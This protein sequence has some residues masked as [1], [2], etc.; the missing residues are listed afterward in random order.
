MNAQAKSFADRFEYEVGGLY[1]LTPITVLSNNDDYIDV[2]T[3]S[4]VKIKGVVKDVSYSGD[5]DTKYE[6]KWITIEEQ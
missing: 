3:E 5:Y 1:G 6:I 4:V 2:K